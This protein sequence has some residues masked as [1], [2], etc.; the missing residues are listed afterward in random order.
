MSELDP[1]LFD[2][3]KLISICKELDFKYQELSAEELKVT[4]CDNIHLIFA[5]LVGDLADDSNR[6][7][8][9]YNDYT[10]VHGIYVQLGV[11]VDPNT[12]E[13]P[14]AHYLDIPLLIRTGEILIY[15]R[16]RHK[17]L[18][19]QWLVYRTDLTREFEDLEPDEEVRII[20]I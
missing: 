19:M 3:S 16:Y 12:F 2:F 7:T 11:T 10:H 5:N 20:R 18:E 4:W 15:E 1:E 6:D 8:M 14:S 17:L 13:C 9:V